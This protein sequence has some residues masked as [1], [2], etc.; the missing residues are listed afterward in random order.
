MRKSKKVLAIGMIFTWWAVISVIVSGIIR[1]KYVTPE[2]ESTYNIASFIYGIGWFITV[3]IS[4][5]ITSD[6]DK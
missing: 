6:S 3:F 1:V 5:A 2:Y 4:C